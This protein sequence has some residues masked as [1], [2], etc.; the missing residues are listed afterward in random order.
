M[1]HRESA[2]IAFLLEQIYPGQRVTATTI[3]DI[4]GDYPFDQVKRAS[5]RLA[6]EVAEG[7]IYD[8]ERLSP[9]LDILAHVKAEREE[10]IGE[11]PQI[12]VPE[13][14]PTRLASQWE[15][16]TLRA[17]ADGLPMQRAMEFATDRLPTQLS[18]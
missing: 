8:V 14:V 12:R 10:R 1:Q 2:R 16:D 9:V 5:L 13:W 4:L 3:H 6:Y 17:I 18:A 15:R 11:A 7:I